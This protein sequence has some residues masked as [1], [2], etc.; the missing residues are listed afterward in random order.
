MESKQKTLIKLL[1]KESFDS[2]RNDIL[3]LFDG[4]HIVTPD[5]L[6]KVL[7]CYKFDDGRNKALSIILDEEFEFTEKILERAL[8]C[9]K[10]ESGRK[11]ALSIIKEH[12]HF[13]PSRACLEFFKFDGEEVEDKDGIIVNGIKVPGNMTSTVLSDGSRVE[14]KGNLWFVKNGNCSSVV[15]NGGRVEINRAI[16]S[17]V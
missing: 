5:I 12:T 11:E 17:Y 3:R 15:S 13:V 14:K 9:Y 4:I 2:G 8:S 7:S 1:E 10:F 6:R 16:T